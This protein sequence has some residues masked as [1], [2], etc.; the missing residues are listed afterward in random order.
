MWYHGYG[1][2][3]VVPSVNLAYDHEV[4]VKLK[5]QEGY[6]SDSEDHGDA[7]ID[8]KSKPPAMVKCMPNWE[9]QKW[10]PWDEGL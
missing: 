5:K 10:L 6:V 1:K 4:A 9:G 2:I 7:K 3:A 8:C